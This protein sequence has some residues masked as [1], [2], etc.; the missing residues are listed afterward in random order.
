MSKLPTLEQSQVKELEAKVQELQNFKD[1]ICNTQKFSALI[2]T[3]S[4]GAERLIT[5]GTKVNRE[6]KTSDKG[7]ITFAFGSFKAP[8]KDAKGKVIQ[9]VLFQTFARLNY[10]AKD[11]KVEAF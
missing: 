2:V 4:E 3:D 9:Q 10:S 11:N 1:R 8:L 5:F 7:S 6:G